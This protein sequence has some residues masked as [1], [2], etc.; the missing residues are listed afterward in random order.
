MTAKLTGLGREIW[1]N[2]SGYL[3]IAP[4]YLAFVAFM[5]L[6]LAA[7]IGLSFYKASFAIDQRQFV[8]LEQYARLFDDTKFQKALVNT[9]KYVLV[10]VPATL[11]L[12]LTISLLVHPR[13]IRAQSFYR[14]AFYL[15]GVA[16]GVILSVVW[17]WIFNPTFG[18]LNFLLG[19]VGIEPVLWLGS[20]KYSFWAVCMVVLTFTIGQPIILFLAGLAN[21]NQDVL[22]ACVVDGAN[23]WQRTWFVTLPLLRPVILFVIAT[24]TIGVFQIW[25]T[26]YML[27]E[28]GPSNSSISL[29]FFIYQTAFIAGRYGK[30]SAIGVVLL[31]LVAI[32]TFVQLRFWDRTEV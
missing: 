5:L 22:D 28:G 6:P 16:G 32:V 10:V 15:P 25:E 11:G 19:S 23:S 18:L 1:R 13:G 21:L 4:G 27:T 2:R 24:Q 8:G 29:V 17:L 20:A 26:I 12:S 7:A 9:I 31:I 30:A 14:G 3:F